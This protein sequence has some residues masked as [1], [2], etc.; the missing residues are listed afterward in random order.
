MFKKL[1][2]VELIYKSTMNNVRR[3]NSFCY[4]Y[5]IKQSHEVTLVIF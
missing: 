4:T 1:N 2:Y 3:S 5:K